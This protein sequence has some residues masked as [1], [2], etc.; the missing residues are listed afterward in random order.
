MCPYPGRLTRTVIALATAAL[1]VAGSAFAQ[2]TTGTIVGAIVNAQGRPMPRVAVRI[3]DAQHRT[4]RTAQADDEGLFRVAELPPASY[5]ITASADGFRQVSLSDVVVP[6]DTIVRVDMQLLLRTVT[7]NVVVTSRARPVHTSAGLGSVFDRQRIETLPL[8]GRNFLQLSLLA[9]GVADPAEGSELSSR[10]A[11]A[12]HVNGAREESNNFLLDGVDNND[13]YVNRYVVQPSVDSVQEFKIATNGYSAEYGRNAGGQINVVTR[14]GSDRFTGFLY[15]Y[16]RNGALD[17]SNFFD[18]GSKQPFSRNEFGGG[19]GG[20]LVRDR[21]FFFGTLNLLRESQGLSRLGTVPS[22]AARRGDLSGV[23]ATVVNPFTGAPFPGNVIPDAMISPLARQVLSMFPAANRAGSVN[24]IGQP[25][26]N[27]DLNQVNLRV[28]HRLSAADALMV[29]YSD[30]SAHLLE[31]YT[32]GTGV[33]AGFGDLVND[34]TWNATAQYQ[35]MFGRATNSLRVAANGFSRDLAT[36]NH[37]TNVGAAWGVNWLQVP[38]ES[39]G[40]PVVDVAGYSRVGDAFSL[41]ILRDSR[42]YQLAD[43]AT[44]DRGQH[45]VK[46]G[47][48]IR[49][50]QLDSRLD[51]F[52]RGQL[53]FTGAITGSGIGDLLLGLPTL[54][55]QSQADNPIRMRTN[56]VSAY[57]QDEWRLRP[58]LT[59][60]LGARYE[61]IG[62][63]V[64]AR[65]GMTAFNPVT[66]TL[67]P[68]ATQG[69]SRS[70]ISPDRNNLAPRLG[71]SWQVTP[72]TIL[73]AGYGLFYD[74]GMFTVNTSQY[75]NPPQFNLR[76]FFPNEHGLLTLADPFPLSNG[77]VPPPTVS[78][79]SPDLTTGYLQHWNLAVQREYAAIGTVTAAYAGSKGSH[80]IRAI[81][82]NQPA[83]GP[84]DLQA[85]SPYPAFSNIFYTESAGRSQYDS[86]QLTV[87]RPLRNRM[88]LNASYTLSKSMDD[89]SSFLGTP[90]D[91]NFPQNSRDPGAEWAPSSFDVRHRLTLSYIV[92]LP[93]D[94]R[95]TRNLQLQ[96]I[97]IVRSGQPLTPILRFDNSNTGN[98]GGSTAGSDRPNA[99]GDPALETP[100]P[101]Q[102]FNTAAFA[103]PAQ[104]TFGN[105]GRNSVRG[106]GFAT[107]DI[108]LSKEIQSSRG[109]LTF[110]LQVFNLFNRTNFDQ[111]EHFVD[112]P[113][114]FG[115]IFSA[116]APRQVQLVA[117]IGF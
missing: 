17:K 55:I 64:D 68:V 42:T 70:G 92:Q 101:D 26:A 93:G 23:G 115:H 60:N 46:I 78:A 25:T 47:G 58:D 67:T 103:V 4:E 83:P 77:F 32:E 12:I 45:L 117:R 109:T 90:T 52:S 13:V 36:E 107:F 56:A 66:G 10:G 113:T 73:R 79:L 84:G 88:S 38:P 16:F 53:S 91:K 102:W 82:L 33:T 19:A 95:W 61:Y 76:V 39:F 59:L 108:A 31:P 14:R 9:P 50:L 74:S 105:A 69:V 81:D 111:P 98:A 89:A 110:A 15:E 100:T 28:D 11:V 37:Q 21:T 106:P 72:S 5:E 85:R 1:A 24:Y 97:A 57:V 62:P 116:K 48:E 65:D 86:L 51:L 114:T 104:Y 18:E 43:D 63:P 3:A 87:N 34:R 27:N 112:E 94:N 7:E 96:G 6:V 54:G 41:P 71:A 2:V 30:G 35:R 40:Y 22:E 80:L 99:I 49:R 44:F 8:N 29:R 75:F 20:P